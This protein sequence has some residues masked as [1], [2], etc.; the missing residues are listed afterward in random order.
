MGDI[1]SDL[2]QDIWSSF[3]TSRDVERGTVVHS[4]FAR[5]GLRSHV[6]LAACGAEGIAYERAGRGLFTVELL[7][8]FEEIGI[9]KLSYAS[10][11][12][13]RMQPLSNG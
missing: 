3:E 11:F 7:K 10:L 4:G 2:D 5:N 9:D 8:V 13:L 12:A 1:P 6:L